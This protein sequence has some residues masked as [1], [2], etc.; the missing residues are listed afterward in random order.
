MLYYAEKI[1]GNPTRNVDFDS[2]GEAIEYFMDILGDNLLAVI[3]DNDPEI[4]VVYD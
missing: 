1:N 3:K 4:T 2:E